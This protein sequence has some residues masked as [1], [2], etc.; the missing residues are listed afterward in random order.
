MAPAQQGR[1]RRQPLQQ[2]QAE[3]KLITNPLEDKRKVD[4]CTLSFARTYDETT[5]I[6]INI[7]G[8]IYYLGYLLRSSAA[9]L[10]LAYVEKYDNTSAARPWPADG[11]NLQNARPATVLATRCAPLNTT[12][13]FNSSSA[14]ER[15]RFGEGP[16]TFVLPLGPAPEKK[17][18]SLRAKRPE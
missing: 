8:L 18:T 17:V 1:L 15:K 9:H 16:A 6:T 11:Q 10:V 14:T 4:A 3:T 7:V 13:T 2:K 5:P 12:T